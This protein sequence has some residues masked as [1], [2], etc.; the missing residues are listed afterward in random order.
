MACGAVSAAT[1]RVPP[2]SVH[3]TFVHMSLGDFTS[4][5][6]VHKKKGVG[7]QACSAVNT[8]QPRWAGFQDVPSP[9]PKKMRFLVHQWENRTL[10]SRLPQDHWDH[11]GG[12]SQ[13]PGLKSEEG[14]L[15]Q[16]PTSTPEARQISIVHF[17]WGLKVSLKT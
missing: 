8:R 15:G 17:V 16:H 11:S 9:Q 14:R 6:W 7:S 10:D 1:P 13:W 12:I 3:D 2:A 5:L 4:G